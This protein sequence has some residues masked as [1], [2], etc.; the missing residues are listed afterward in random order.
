VI[1]AIWLLAYAGLA[2]RAA[3]VWWP[4][5]ALRWTLI[6]WGVI[7]VGLGVLALV[8]PAATIFT[9]LFFGAVYAALFGA[10]QVAAGLWVRHLLHHEGGHHAPAVHAHA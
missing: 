8:Y 3:V 9:L 4:F 1:V 5:R 7:D 10:W 2:W 6:A